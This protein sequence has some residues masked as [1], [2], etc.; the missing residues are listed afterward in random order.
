MFVLAAVVVVTE[1][2]ERSTNIK[3]RAHTPNPNQNKPQ[4]DS[5][6]PEIPKTLLVEK[7]DLQ[8]QNSETS[9]KKVQTFG[10]RT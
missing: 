10:K 7:F 2:G 1:E 6:I 4:E 9:K 3:T 5:K 8:N